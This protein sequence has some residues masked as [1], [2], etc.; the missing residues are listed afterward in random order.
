MMALLF[1]NEQDD[2]EENDLRCEREAENRSIA[3]LSHMT[4]T[5]CSQSCSARRMS[6]LQIRHYY[7]EVSANLHMVMK[8]LRKTANV[9][10]ICSD[11]HVQQIHEYFTAQLFRVRLLNTK[12]TL[13]Y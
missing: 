11:W 4:E 6:R 1:L 9:H 12:E 10:D 8:P 5:D 7:A 13:S 2:D 3:K